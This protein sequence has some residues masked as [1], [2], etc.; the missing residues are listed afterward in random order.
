ML[1]IHSIVENLPA[2]IVHS[3]ID[4]QNI[5]IENIIAGDLMSDILVGVESPCLIITSLA[6]SQVIR[7]GDIVGASAILLVNDKLPSREMKDLAEKSDITLLATPLPL[8]EACASLSVIN[9]FN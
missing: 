5:V 3:S 4:Y 9:T 6:T 8:Y 2:H 7:T 1:S